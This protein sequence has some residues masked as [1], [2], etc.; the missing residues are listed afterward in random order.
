MQCV[1]VAGVTG[2]AVASVAAAAVAIAIGIGIGIAFVAGDA[3][4]GAMWSF[5]NLAAVCV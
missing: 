2:V 4:S 3:G 5:T 1:D